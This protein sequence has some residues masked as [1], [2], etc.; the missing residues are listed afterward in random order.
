[1]RQRNCS[2]QTVFSGF[3]VGVRFFFP[4]FLFLLKFVFDQIPFDQIR[5]FF[6]SN[7]FFS[8]LKLLRNFCFL[9]N[10]AEISMQ[11]QE[12]Y[13]TF[14]KFSCMQYFSLNLKIL[15]RVTNG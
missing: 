8:Y 7:G 6:G 10:F 15:L 9:F 5:F 4:M 1:M 3:L 2:Q 11:F 14:N 12:E 13:S